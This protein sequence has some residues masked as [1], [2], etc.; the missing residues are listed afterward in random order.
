[1]LRIIDQAFDEAISLGFDFAE[2]LQVATEQAEER[3][4]LLNKIKIAFIEC[5][6]E[7][8]DYFA[9]QLELGAGVSIIPLV[10]N[11]I[12]H[13][14]EHVRSVAAQ[15]DLVVTTYFHEDEVRAMIPPDK[16]VLAIALD[17]HLETI[18]RIA[19]IPRGQRLGLV[20]L[21]TNFTEKVINSIRSAGIDYLFVESTISM[22]ES[23]VRGVIENC[24]VLLVSPGRY[25]EV[26]KLCPPG[27]DIIEFVYRPDWGSINMLKSALLEYE[28]KYT[29]EKGDL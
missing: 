27:K 16:Q 19:R 12:R 9:H 14:L 24:D 11:D 23:V 6:R 8:V 15:V 18:V 4:N 2:I 3:Q 26:A 10:L 22:D 25:R 7:Q 5:N 1:M 17:P 28:H 20:C 13:D 21:S 29:K